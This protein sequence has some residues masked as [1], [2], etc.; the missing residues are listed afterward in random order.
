[1]RAQPDTALDL[2]A[3]GF[4]LFGRAN[5]HATDWGPGGLLETGLWLEE[6][7][8]VHAGAGPTLAAARA[9]RYLETDAGRVGLVS[10]T[11]SP[12]SG[13]APALDAFGEVPA[14]PG[15]TRCRCGP[16]WS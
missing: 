10:M 4:D 11:T 6:A 5:N 16:R 8:L 3:L 2:R 15:C 14:R 7:A 1:M 13:L 12:A 9:P